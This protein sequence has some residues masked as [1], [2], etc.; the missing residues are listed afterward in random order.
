MLNLSA[1]L[2]WLAAAS[3]T[4]VL[5][6]TPARADAIDGSWCH[7]DGRRLSILGPLIVTPAGTRTQ[8]DYSRHGFAYV[9][10]VGEAQA[11]TAIRMT[12]INDNLM[13]LAAGENAPEHWRRCGPPIS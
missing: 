10:P 9:A 12:L 1:I 3:V 13:R 8:G 4:I 11:G 5:L 6:Q 7:E 2:R